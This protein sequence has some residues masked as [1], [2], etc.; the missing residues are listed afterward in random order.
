[1][2][3]KRSAHL[4]TTRLNETKATGRQQIY[5]PMRKETFEQ[6]IRAE[7]QREMNDPPQRSGA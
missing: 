2:H 5:F 7:S 1:M 3:A 4:F 6:D